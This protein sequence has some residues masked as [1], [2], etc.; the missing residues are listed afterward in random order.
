MKKSYRVLFVVGLAIACAVLSSEVTDYRAEAQGRVQFQKKERKVET[1]E[2][3][4]AVSLAGLP[5][6]RI[7]EM[8]SD[9][10]GTDAAEFIELATT[11]GASL[12][13]FVMVF[14]NGSND[15]SYTALDLDGLTADSN[16]F[17]MLGN[18]GIPGV[19]LTFAG[20]LLQNGQDAIA[21]YQG[22][23]SSFPN[24][25]PITT[26]N[27]VDA[28]VYDT[29]D[30]DD[31]NLLALLNPGPAQVQIDE[32]GAT[33]PAENSIQ[34]CSPAL[35]DGRAFSVGLPTPN[36]ANNICVTP[37][38]PNVDMNGDG[39]T[40]YVITREI[41]SFFTNAERPQRRREMNRDRKRAR[42]ARMEPESADEA[43]AGSIPIEWW[44]VNNDAPGG[45]NV[46]WGDS[47]FLDQTIS[48]DFDGDDKDDVAIWRPGPPD[49]AAFYS[50]NS[51][52]LTYRVQA[53]GQTLDDVA[54]VGDY[55]GDG[56]DDSAS[57]RCP[58]D[59]GPAG[60]CYFFYRASSNNPTNG[61]TYIPWGFGNRSD[62]SPYP[63]DF[64]GD[65]KYDFCLQGVNPDS[66]AHGV[67]LLQKNDANYSQ[68]YIHWGLENDWL[69]PGDYDGDGRSDFAVV[70]FE[71]DYRVFYILHRTGS[72]RAAQWGLADDD[73]V[74]GDYDGDG[75]Q[76]IAVYRW[77][78]PQPTFWVLPSNGNPHFA[79]QFGLT[80]DVPVATWYV[81]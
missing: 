35:R 19:D 66:P 54:V 21:L 62:F 46:V 34:R 17:V 12:N 76:D 32:T 53:F 75:K 8:D 57:F 40:D 55:D 22:D 33:F 47:G 51:S 24:G 65:G 4:K 52:D 3:S 1:T 16:G 9:T 72:M 27:L 39:R 77:F 70:R 28:V 60:Q 18:V 58:S 61:I 48:A 69:A 7:N 31:L 50:I 56:K 11:P 26:T 41:F 6:V 67:F 10:E 20:N 38:K 36:A 74:P 45:T 30:P 37:Q 64:D 73:V 13:G 81:Q 80:G 43:Q 59:G 15:Q 71:G 79:F 2:L 5:A 25:T 68:E 42:M 44:G 14:Y 63:G 49:T 23:A 29:A 78:D